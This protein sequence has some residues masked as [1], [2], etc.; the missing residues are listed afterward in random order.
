MKALYH[1]TSERQHLPVI[2]ASG[3]LRGRA[4]MAGA[5]PLIWFSAHP[6]WEPTATKP[7]WMGGLL[8]PQTFEEYYDVF[9]CVRFALPTCDGRLMDWRRACKFAG[10]PKRDR[11]ALESVGAKE[12]GHPRHWFALA[13]PVPLAE[14]R[15]EQL[16]GS[17]WQSLRVEEGASHV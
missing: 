7:R 2:L 11:W 10:I 6:F 16:V 13:G 14:L 5:R 9:G 1:Y 3:E 17:Q 4:D 8:V 15:A 12:G